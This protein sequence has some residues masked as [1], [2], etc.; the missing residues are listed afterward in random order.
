MK[1]GAA[2]YAKRKMDGFYYIETVNDK[3]LTTSM[4]RVERDS[5]PEDVADRCDALQGHAYNAVELGE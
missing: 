3:R 4:V 1:L 2:R 5:L